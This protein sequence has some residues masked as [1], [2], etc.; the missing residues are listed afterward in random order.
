MLLSSPFYDTYQIIVI[1]CK[2]F[3]RFIALVNIK[4]HYI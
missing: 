1:Y 4:K 2:L 3:N